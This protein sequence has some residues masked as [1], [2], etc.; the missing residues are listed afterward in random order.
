M[1]TYKQ[2]V[3]ELS[4]E[5]V[6]NRAINKLTINREQQKII[7]TETIRKLWDYSFNEILSYKNF[8]P[9]ATVLQSWEEFADEIYGSRKPS[10]L[11]IAFFCGP[12]PENDLN[13]LTK[14][15]VRVENVWA[16]EMDGDIYKSALDSAKEKYPTL[17][18]FNGDIADLMQITSFKFDV[19]YLDFTA[20]LL[21][22]KPASIHT[23]NNIFENNSLADLGILIVNSALPNPTEDNIDFLSSYFASHT[24]LEKSIYSGSDEDSYHIEGRL[25]NGY[26]TKREVAESEDHEEKIFE[27][28]I[29]DNFSQAYGAFSSHYPYL[30]ASY[31][32]PMFKVAS[33]ERL[34]KL[35]FNQNEDEINKAIKKISTPNEDFDQ[36]I[37][38]EEECIS[39]KEFIE[40]L[41]K[42]CSEK[43]NSCQI[44]LG[45][46]LKFSGKAI[47]E[48]EEE[49]N[50]EGRELFEDAENY[51]FWSFVDYLSDSQGNAC[52]FWHGEFVKNRH[53]KISYLKCAQLYD[54]L[55]NGS[56]IYKKILSTILSS[57]I[58][59]V[60]ESIPDR[61]KPVFCDVPMPHLWVE[62]ALNHLGNAYHIN[63]SQ[64][65]R[66]RYKAKDREMY[67]DMFSFDNCRPLY[68]WLP[69]LELYGNDLKAMERQ[70]IIRACMDLITKQSHYLS[71]VSY[72]GANLVDA[73]TNEWPNFS[74]F[75]SRINLN[76]IL[77]G[78]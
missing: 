53:N 74:E 27:D 21:T 39:A 45:A 1:T 6:W 69:M 71:T 47:A 76:E 56:Y 22:K 41:N 31:L 38:K 68:D 24:F 10:N 5:E 4:R 33:S 26:F 63:T 58:S 11:K 15:G 64:H 17:K 35:F 16:I 78:G 50:F 46:T 8:N 7:K 67:L 3:K 30:F 61:Q 36:Y 9:N 62:L 13:I 49:D 66:A 54:L 18:I 42:R 19:I 23:I 43:G 70:V 28:L 73:H 44:D 2:Q 14:L 32:A 20:T 75:N 34:R 12:E 51:P 57:C 52:K 48:D 37:D 40:Y 59:E 65:W 55:R 72:Y 25:C 77:N 29:R 60:E